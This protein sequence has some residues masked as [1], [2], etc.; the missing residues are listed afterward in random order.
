MNLKPLIKGIN[1][2]LPGGISV[3][4]FA[5]VAETNQIIAKEI[6]DDLVK[7]EI[8]VFDNNVINFKS[9]DKLKSAL[10]A[11]RKGA[12]IEEIS[13]HLNWKDFEGLTANI[14]EAKGFGTIRNLILTKP[15]MEIDVI[16]IKLGMSILI[17]CKHWKRQSRSSLKA[18][19]EKQIARVKHYVSKTPGAV[20][21]PT[22]V[23]LFQDEL[24]FINKIPI[25]P[26]LQFSSFVDEFYGNLD[27]VLTIET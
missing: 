22:I 11:L 5:V 18:A 15:R 1:G 21:V 2:I 26:I 27:K 14:L 7:N 3:K 24:S 13:K 20:A 10:F 8:G 6:L 19:V 17:D 4:D 23:T 9:G 25:V 16:G 12:P